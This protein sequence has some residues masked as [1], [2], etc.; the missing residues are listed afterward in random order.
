MIRL[1]VLYGGVLCSSNSYPYFG[2]EYPYSLTLHARMLEELR[3]GGRGGGV[4][5]V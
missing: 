3:A 2:I 5:M 4:G 1:E